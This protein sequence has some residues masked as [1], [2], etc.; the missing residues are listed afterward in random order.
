M[1]VGRIV[2]PLPV[3]AEMPGQQHRHQIGGRH[4][5]R[6]MAGPG[7]G[8]GTDRVDPQLLGELMDVIQR[9]HG[10]C[11]LPFTPY[12]GHALPGAA[13]GQA[14]VADRVLASAAPMAY[15][16]PCLAG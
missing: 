14:H 13:A 16:R 9:L 8:A 6:R 10:H 4:A 15:V 11:A 7:G 12:R 2:R 5:R 1:V 3:V